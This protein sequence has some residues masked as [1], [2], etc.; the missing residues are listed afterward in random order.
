MDIRPS[1]KSY[2]RS[3]V[4]NKPPENLIE[5]SDIQNVFY[6]HQASRMSK[7]DIGPTKCLICASDFQNVF[8][9]DQSVRSSYMDMIHPKVLIWT[10][11]L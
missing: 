4:D 9:G 1:R 2:I 6:R 11:D 10:L 8:N 3:F 7:M 5:T